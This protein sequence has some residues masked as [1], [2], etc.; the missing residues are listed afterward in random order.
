M[1]GRAPATGRQTVKMQ[2]TDATRTELKGTRLPIGELTSAASRFLSGKDAAKLAVLLDTE[3]DEK[4]E[5]LL[6]WVADF[7]SRGKTQT[8]VIGFR[9]KYVK[10]ARQSLPQEVRTGYFEDYLDINE[11]GAIDLQA[12]DWILNWYRLDCHA[13]YRSSLRYRDIPLGTI[14]EYPLYHVFPQLLKKV[15]NVATILARE[16]PSLLVLLTDDPS[17]ER[18]AVFLGH[19]SNV[20][21]VALP[22]DRQRDTAS[23]RVSGPIEKMGR[24]R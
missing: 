20:P 2:K 19:G 7:S 4:A 16:K 1:P 6:T 17:L 9:K 8:S 3:S 21:V 15:K 11:A 13:G 22:E 5:R 18:V 10:Q 14:V 24:T 12:R 23:P